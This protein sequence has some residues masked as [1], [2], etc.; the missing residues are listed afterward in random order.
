MSKQRGRNAPAFAGQG[1]RIEVGSGY[2]FNTK[3]PFVELIVGKE[4]VQLTAEKAREIAGWLV[5]A[6]DSAEGDGFVVEW[7][8]EGVAGFTPQ[9]A[10]GLLGDFRRFR[11]AK[12]RAQQRHDSPP[13]ESA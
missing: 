12:R 4:T 3:L 9:Q 5:A 8:A 2:G 10:A 11:D 13:A 6:A 7:L 1:Q